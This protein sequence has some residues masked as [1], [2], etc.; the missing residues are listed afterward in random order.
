MCSSIS[1]WCDGTADCLDGSDEHDCANSTCPEYTC[2]DG[3]C[4]PHRWRCDGTD[5]CDDDELG[6]SYQSKLI[7]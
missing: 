2:G 7:D 4:I 5:D 6:E 1:R 3:R